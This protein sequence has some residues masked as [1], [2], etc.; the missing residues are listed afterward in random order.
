MAGRPRYFV[1]VATWLGI[2]LFLFLRVNVYLLTGY[3]GR[4]DNPP[5]VFAAIK[6]VLLVLSI[7]LLVGLV[8]LRPNF[9]WISVAISAWSALTLMGLWC[10]AS[11]A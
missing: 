1:L 10:S 8:E 6:I 11:Q 2:Y 4:M 3:L 7:W 5:T 9:I